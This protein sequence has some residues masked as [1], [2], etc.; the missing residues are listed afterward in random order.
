MITGDPTLFEELLRNLT[1]NAINYCPSGSHT[2]VRV[3]KSNGEAVIEVEDNGPGIPQED[4]RKVF[5]RFYRLPSSNVH[6][7]GLGLP[8][9]REIARQQGGDAI[10]LSG[11]NGKGT[12]ARVAVPINS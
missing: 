1:H 11:Q 10:I 4:H 8:I 9:V 5:E 6:G 2:S 3:L 12:L 7:C